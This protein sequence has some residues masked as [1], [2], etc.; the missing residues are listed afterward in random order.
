MNRFYA[1]SISVLT[2]LVTVAACKP[3]Q[4]RPAQAAYTK[5]P[6]IYFRNGLEITLG[7]ASVPIHGVEECPY[8]LAA[9]AG[10][11]VEL[12]DAKCIG[13]RTIPSRSS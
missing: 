6:T 9:P 13:C 7:D 4:D 2:A 11:V 8:G 1:L 12:N 5:E 3:S 10:A